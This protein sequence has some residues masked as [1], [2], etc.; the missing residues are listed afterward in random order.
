MR[1]RET[2]LLAFYCRMARRD[3]PKLGGRTSIRILTI[4]TCSNNCGTR[5]A[6]VERGVIRLA[7]KDRARKQKRRLGSIRNR[8]F[9]EVL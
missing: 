2:P 9:R 8:A 5:T 4:I 6:S 7:P 3:K 1:D